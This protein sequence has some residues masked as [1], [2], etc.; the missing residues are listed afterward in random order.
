MIVSDRMA[1]FL[2]LSEYRSKGAVAY[3]MDRPMTLLVQELIRAFEKVSEFAS[4]HNGLPEQECEA[5]LFVLENSSGI[6]NRIVLSAITNTMIRKS[7]R[8]SHG[9]RPQ[10]A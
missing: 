1:P 7:V 4:D 5:V 9:F 8:L 2:G 6:S 10:S 3:R